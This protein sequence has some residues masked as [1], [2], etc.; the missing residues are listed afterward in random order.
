MGKN[1]FKKNKKNF[2]SKEDNDDESE[3]AEI[4]L[5]GQQIQMRNQKWTQ[6]LN[7]W[8]LLMKLKNVGKGTNLKE[9]LT[10]Y[11]EETNQ[12]IMDLK[13][14]LQEAK[15]TE[16]DLVVMLKERIQDFEKLEKDIIKLRKG[17]DEKYIKSKFE[18]NS[19]IC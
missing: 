5:Q 19:R 10:K 4:Y 1:K 12:I 13:N 6:K 17:V 16:E 8:L 11:Q 15:K 3:D 14:Q 2:Y 18:N 7:T 9:K